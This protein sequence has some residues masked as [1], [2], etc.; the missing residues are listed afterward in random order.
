V[1]DDGGQ[2]PSILLV[3]PP[4]LVTS[5]E[6]KMPLVLD[7]QAI[8][9]HFAA[10]PFFLTPKELTLSSTALID[11]LPCHQPCSST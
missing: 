6:M 3:L 8:E 10:T 11:R 4:P 2:R 9:E 5:Q 1:N 7:N